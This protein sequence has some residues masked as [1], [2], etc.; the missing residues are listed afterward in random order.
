MK[1]R[2]LIQSS[3][4]PIL[5]LLTGLPASGKSTLAE[6]LKQELKARENF[7]NTFIID[8]D[9]I[10]FSLFGKEFCH[11]NEKFTVNEKNQEIE[12]KLQPG[13]VVIADDLHYL[14]SMRHNFYEM[15]LKKSALYI[16]IFISTPAS[17]CK[18]WNEKRG[19]T[20]PQNVIDDIAVKFDQ[21]GKKYRWDKINLNF[22]LHSQDMSEIIDEIFQNIAI[23][24]K[25]KISEVS[26]TS[27]KE[28][29]YQNIK[30][31]E[32][33]Q[34]DKDSR[35]IIHRIIKR[36]Y[37]DEI[38]K[39]IGKYLLIN[40]KSFTKEISSLRK[41]FVKWAINKENPK[42]TIE[43]FLTFLKETL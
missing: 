10:R 34:F 32:I 28:K 7:N 1:L 31:T 36:E 11:I 26:K 16:P 42:I 17:Q 25:K 24:L 3:K 5:I 20:V 21:P 22:D 6:R 15:C 29:F 2:Y 4:I 19:L 30:H 33:A 40:S 13:N 8:T 35:L 41:N 38:L 39:E 18:K 23:E 43:D 14:T 9:V 37:S 27:K 12:E